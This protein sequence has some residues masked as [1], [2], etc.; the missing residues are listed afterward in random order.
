MK[1]FIDIRYNIFSDQ[2]INNFLHLFSQNSKSQDVYDGNNTTFLD[3]EGVDKENMA[4]KYEPYIGDNLIDWCQMVK[5][6]ENSYQVNH[7]D[8]AS[9]KTTI[10]SITFLNDNFDGGETYFN[11]GTIIRPCKNKTIFFSGL[12]IVHGV[13]KVLN[14]ERFTIATWYK[15]K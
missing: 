10:A 2:E 13:K 9:D 12:L 3:I 7:L 15:K 6:P 4:K 5:W 8:R 11:E 14:G 1:P